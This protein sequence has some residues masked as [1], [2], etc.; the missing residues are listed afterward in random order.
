MA[1]TVQNSTGTEASANAYVTAAEF[2]EYHKDRGNSISAYSTSQIQAA[3]VRATDYLDLRFMYVGE[4][5]QSPQSTEWPRLNGFDI[6][7][8]LING[9]P[10]EVKEATMEYALIA[11]SA[12]INPVPLRDDT[13][14]IVTRKKERVGPIEEDTRYTEGPVFTMPKYPPADLKLIRRGLVVQGGTARRGD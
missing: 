13:G 8:D 5:A 4:R 10:Q 6:E 9:I 12:T 3:I 1:F 14:Q 7:E 11:L 2:K